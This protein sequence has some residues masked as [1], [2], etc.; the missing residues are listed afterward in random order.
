VRQRECVLNFEIVQGQ[1]G[2]IFAF[3]PLARL[4][5]NEEEECETGRSDNLQWLVLY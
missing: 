1:T 3:T 5:F 4:L 2:R